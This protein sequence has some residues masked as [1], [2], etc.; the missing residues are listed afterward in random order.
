MPGQSRGGIAVSRAIQW[1]YE[2]QQMVQ[3][4]L[5]STR[6]LRVQRAYSLVTF[7]GS[8]SPAK[9]EDLTITGLC[10]RRGGSRG[11]TDGA[12]FSMFIL[13]VSLFSQAVSMWNS[14][15]G[16][17][18]RPYC[19]FCF[20][21]RADEF[22]GVWAVASVALRGPA[23]YQTEAESAGSP[24]GKKHGLLYRLTPL[25]PLLLPLPFFTLSI[26]SRRVI[27]SCFCVKG[28]TWWGFMGDTKRT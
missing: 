2:E 21:H 11:G 1:R 18:L 10:L 23:I 15:E 27:Q 6:K 22:A 13:A 26:W 25:S 20:F 9:S 12:L 14:R 16:P 4:A 19:F 8:A 24:K 5:K 28:I 7:L 17:W 3:K